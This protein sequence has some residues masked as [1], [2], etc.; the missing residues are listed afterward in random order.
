MVLPDQELFKV[1]LMKLSSEGFQTAEY[2]LEHG[3]ID[4]VIPR[5]NLKSAIANTI[6]LLRK[7]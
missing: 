2:L 5:K 3:M 6:S 4:D 1:R 7:I